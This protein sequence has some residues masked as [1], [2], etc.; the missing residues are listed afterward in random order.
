MSW[1]TD[2]NQLILFSL[3]LFPPPVFFLS[4]QHEELAPC[5]NL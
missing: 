3:L 5:L 4:F 2:C 1:F